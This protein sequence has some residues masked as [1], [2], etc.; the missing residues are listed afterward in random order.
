MPIAWS[1]AVSLAG[2]PDVMLQPL[3]KELGCLVYD[4]FEL[5][6]GPLNSDGSLPADPMSTIEW[7]PDVMEGSAAYGLAA[8]EAE[9][10]Q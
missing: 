6:C 1:V 7:A 8:E 9:E 2:M 3:K 4:Y 5:L 10:E